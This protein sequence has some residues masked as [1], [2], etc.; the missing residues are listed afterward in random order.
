MSRLGK[1]TTHTNSTY[2]FQRRQRFDTATIG[3]ISARTKETE[4]IIASI[5]H[6]ASDMLTNLPCP[7]SITQRQKD[8]CPFFLIFFFSESATSIRQLLRSFE[9]VRSGPDLC[10][11]VRVR[12]VGRTPLRPCTHIHV[13]AIS[14]VDLWPR[15]PINVTHASP[16]RRRRRASRRFARTVGA[17]SRVFVPYDASHDA[18]ALRSLHT[19]CTIVRDI[20]Y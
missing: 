8:V 6:S 4:A 19:C 16:A 11:G 9:F 7:P 2:R 13:V 10:C 17:K 14:R 1:R 5:D 18:C 20:L 15:V 12:I 3:K